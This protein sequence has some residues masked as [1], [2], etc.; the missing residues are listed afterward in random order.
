MLVSGRVDQNIITKNPV[1]PGQCWAAGARSSAH[2]PT[3]AET[4]DTGGGFAASRAVFD[5]I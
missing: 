5:A 3:A 1:K 4:V 2:S